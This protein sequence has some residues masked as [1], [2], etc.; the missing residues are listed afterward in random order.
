MN[1]EDAKMYKKLGEMIKKRRLDLNLS[2]DDV[3]DM[4]SDTEF[5]KT[6]STIKRYEDGKSKISMGF[7]IA[8]SEILDFNYSEYIEKATSNC[9][10]VGI[11][12]INMLLLQYSLEKEDYEF[13]A[14]FIKM[15]DEQKDK[16]KKIVEII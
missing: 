4:L 8:L 5:P 15:S 16:L 7:I 3:V 12:M 11:D 10:R 6:K 13:I 2:L 1:S 9:E 14:R